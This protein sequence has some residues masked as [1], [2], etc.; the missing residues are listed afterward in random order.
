VDGRTDAKEM[1]SVVRQLTGHRKE[2]GDI[3]G[4][5]AELMDSYYAGVS[6]DNHCRP[7]LNK[8]SVSQSN[9]QEQ[10]VTDWQA[11]QNP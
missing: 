2:V 1:C 6:T 8:H 9:D 7:P 4:I 11:F 5:S 10:Y 3:A